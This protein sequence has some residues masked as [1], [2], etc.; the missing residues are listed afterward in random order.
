MLDTGHVAA[1]WVILGQRIDWS[2]DEEFVGITESEFDHERFSPG[3][4]LPPRLV[5]LASADHDAT[6]AQNAVAIAYAATVTTENQTRN[7]FLSIPRASTAARVNEGPNTTLERARP[8]T[9]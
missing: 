2:R 7:R 6:H 1:R 5:L 8:G 9:P 3:D 4:G